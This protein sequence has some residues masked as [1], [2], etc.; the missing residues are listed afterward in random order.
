M[1][2]DERTELWFK[3]N[4]STYSLLRGSKKQSILI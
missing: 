4:R 3:Q 2:D 1:L